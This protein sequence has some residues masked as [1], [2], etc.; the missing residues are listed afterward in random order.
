MCESDF[1]GILRLWRDVTRFRDERGRW[2]RNALRKYAGSAFLNAR[3]VMEWANVADELTEL[4]E[5]EWH[6]GGGQGGG[7]GARSAESK[8]RGAKNG[9]QQTEPSYPYAAIHRSLLAG[10]PRQFGWWDRENKAYRSASG[11]FFAV[12]PGSGLFGSARKFEW[13]VAME[14]VETSRLW[15]RR[16]AR[17]DPEW[18]EAVAPHLCRSKYGEAHWDES[19]GAVYGKETVICGGLPVITG[20]RVHYGRVDPKA[21]HGIF[22]REGLLGGGL[23][24]RG[25]FLDHLTE[26]RGE[27][28]AI[29]QK[30]RR[31]GGLWSDEAVLRFFEQ[32]VP[33][34][35][36][37]AAAFHKW[38]GSHEDAL[39]LAL[40]DVLDEDLEALGLDRFPD[41]LTHE[42][43]EYQVYYHA[44]EGERDDGVT[45]GVHVDQLPKLPTLAAGVGRGWQPARARRDPAARFAQ[46]L[47]PGL[48]ADRIGGGRLRG[49]MV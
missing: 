23:R 46:G 39:M 49:V 19:H 17:I 3:R 22:L 29:E 45:L 31:P 14:L 7:G 25:R 41:T 34:E 43:D 12:F 9:D 38:L 26:M 30:L 48:P 4:I 37:T 28:E 16:V 27:I 13:V 8:Q 1:I 6:V 35:I 5:R 18:V 15:A 2:K 10:V 21:A 33:E 42:G 40:A 24:Q 11:G 36:H 44:K 32:R 20:R 47:P